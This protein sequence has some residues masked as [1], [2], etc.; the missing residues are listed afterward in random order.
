M[1]VLLTGA[2]GNIGHE[3]IKHLLKKGHQVRCLDLDTKANRQT[4]REFK[5]EVETLWSDVT[6]RPDVE[7]AVK[8]QDAV[9]HLANYI[10]VM[11]ME[12]HP[13]EARK[14]NVGGTVNVIEA[15]KAGL[16]Q[17]RKL[18]YISSIGVWGSARRPPPGLKASDPVNPVTVY[19][20]QKVECEELVK[21]SG[22]DWC[23]LRLAFAPPLKGGRIEMAAVLFEAPLD[24]HLDFVDPRD[25][26]L[27]VANSATSSEVWG[28]TLLIGGGSRNQMVY[29][30]FS[31][32]FWGFLGAFLEYAF[33]PP[34]SPAWAEWVDSSESQRLLNY[35]NHT[36]QD[37]VKEMLATMAPGWRRHLIPLVAPLVRRRILQQSRYY[38]AAM[39]RAA[40]QAK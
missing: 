40:H 5:G 21:N 30:D 2:F 8:G 29:R 18:I 4:A 28:K 15:M 10:D 33:A 9:V 39:Q 6:S 19:G 13:D 1:R 26:G 7:A 31:K 32:T 20:R 36:L 11:W 3:T 24:A 38:K 37:F 12:T 17:G 34:D 23:I 27:A 35:Q 25:V 14:V 16:P 22:L